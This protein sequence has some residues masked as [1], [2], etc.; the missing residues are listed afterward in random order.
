MF[1]PCW[2]GFARAR[3]TYVIFSRASCAERHYACSSS[4]V[5]SCLR[6]NR[7]P[8]GTCDFTKQLTLSDRQGRGTSCSVNTCQFSKPRVLCSLAGHWLVSG[9]EGRSRRLL[10]KRGVG[11]LTVPEGGRGHRRGS[12][13]AQ[14][15]SRG[16]LRC[17]LGAPRGLA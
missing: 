12:G 3:F 10:W 15:A 6:G 11:V 4:G 7:F 13:A 16:R 8:R 5:P 1:F 14:A 9:D 17:C 2:I